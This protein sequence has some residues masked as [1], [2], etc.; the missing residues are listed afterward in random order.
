MAF[1][2]LG[3]TFFLSSADFFFFFLISV[4]D[5]SRIKII[6]GFG[7]VV[8]QVRSQMVFHFCKSSKNLIL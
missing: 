2:D 6:Y 7:K 8:M 1:D 4:W 3:G 5:K